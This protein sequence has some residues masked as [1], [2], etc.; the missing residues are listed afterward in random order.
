MRQNSSDAKQFRLLRRFEF[1]EAPVPGGRWRATVKT[2]G[3][4]EQLPLLR[5]QPGG[6]GNADKNIRA[7]LCAL[8]WAFSG[9]MP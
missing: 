2:N 3:E 5:V 6:A 1:R 9:S 4:R 8:L 7:S